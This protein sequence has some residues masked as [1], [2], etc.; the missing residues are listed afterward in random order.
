MS[1]QDGTAKI[2]PPTRDRGDAI[3]AGFMWLAK[4]SLCIVAIA[5]GVV[6][7]YVGEQIDVR[8]APP[9]ESP[10]PAPE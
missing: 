4:W 8:T 9:P 2:R 6:A 3:G 7:R 1:E 10:E 5:A